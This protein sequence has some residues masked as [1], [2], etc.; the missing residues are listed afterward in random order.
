M[1]EKIYLQ[2]ILT[3]ALSSLTTPL[4]DCAEQDQPYPYFSLSDFSGVGVDDSC[5]R[6]W[7]IDFT[8]SAYSKYKG[9]KEVYQIQNQV[10][11]A[12]SYLQDVGSEYTLVGIIPQTSDVSKD[13]LIRVGTQTFMAIVTKN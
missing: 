2:T 6:R 13:D 3:T 10:D 11:A 8:V 4:V 12:L 9:Y 1:S 7:E 5:T